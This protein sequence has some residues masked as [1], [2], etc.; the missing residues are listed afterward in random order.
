MSV[1]TTDVPSKTGKGLKDGVKITSAYRGGPL[2]LVILG[3]TSV[4]A[5]DATAPPML[6]FAGVPVMVAPGKVIVIAVIAF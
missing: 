2:L 3:V 1:I 6:N 5:P 4:W